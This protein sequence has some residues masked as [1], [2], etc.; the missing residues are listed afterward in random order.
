MAIPRVR[1]NQ[2]DLTPLKE[3][4]VTDRALELIKTATSKGVKVSNRA[5]LIR[6]GISV[7]DADL[8][9]LEGT[10]DTGP[11]PKPVKHTL[12]FEPKTLEGYTMGAVIVDSA[13]QIRAEVL[14]PI[15]GGQAILEFDDAATG[16]SIELFVK[17]PSGEFAG[18][19]S[20]TEAGQRLIRKKADLPGPVITVQPVKP[21]SAAKAAG[22]SA[23]ARLKGRLL[24]GDPKVKVEKVQLLIEVALKPNPTETDFLPI[25]FATTETEGYF[26]T[27]QLV[28]PGPSDFAKLTAAR[29]R[30]GIPGQPPIPIRLASG[31]GGVGSLPERLILFLPAEGAN[32]REASDS[33]AAECACN[34]C[35][36]LDFH[37]RKVLDEFSYFTVVR[38]TEPLIEAYQQEDLDEIN[39]SDLLDDVNDPV[40]R[41]AL[42]G[43]RAPR[44]LVANF[45]SKNRTITRDNAPALVESVKAGQ[46]MRQ[47]LGPARPRRGRLDLNGTAEIDWDE[48]PTVYQ[49]VSV[50]HGH[51]LQFK[52]EWFHDG[53]SIG[54]LLYSLPLAPGQKKQIVVFDWDR[55]E[56]A[57]NVQQLDYQE[58]LYNSLSRDRDVN[59]VASATLQESLEGSSSSRTSSFGFGLGLGAIIPAPVPMGGL[60]GIGGG[61]GSGS[62]SARQTGS[63]TTTASSQQHV[64]DRTVQAANAIRS[65]RATVIQTV[66][67]GERFQ[68]SAE[69]VANYNHCHAMTIQYFEVLRHF[70]VRTRL[71]DVRECLFVPLKMSAFTPK[72]ILRWRGI[73]E[74]CLRRRDLLPAFDALYRIEE[75]RE[76]ATENYYDSIGLPR[77]RFAEEEIQYIEGELF[78]E[79]QL[80]RPR[81]DDSGEFVSA[82]WARWSP[83]LGDP[84]EFFSRFIKAEAKRDEAFARHAGPRIAQAVMDEMQFV[85]ER[86]APGGATTPLP[87]DA[88]LVSDFRHRARL[89]VSLRMSGPAPGIRREHID[90]VRITLDGARGRNV[91]LQE[92]T[93][94]GSLRVIVHSG[95]MRYRTRNLHEPLFAASNIKNDLTAAGDD[96]RVFCPLSQRALRKPRLE[97]VE[98]ANIL[99]AHCNENL[100]YYHQCLWTRMDPQRRFMLLDGVL[101]PGRAN[102]RSVASVVENRLIGVAGN[103]MIMPVAPGYQLDP[104][105]DKSVDLFQHYYEEPLDPAHLSLPTKGVFAEAVMGKCNSCEK[106]EEERFW[107][108]EESPVPD[109]PTTIQ[110]VG[111]P[112]PGPTPV[113][114]QVKDFP[115]P[116]INVQNAPALPDPQGFGALA[117]LLGNANLFRD[118][119][120]L[121]ENQ[122]NALAALQS[123]LQTAQTFGQGAAQLT[124]QAADLAKFN[125]LSEM[126]SKGQISKDDF[127]KFVDKSQSPE[128]S[129]LKGISDA[130]K[131]SEIDPESAARLKDATLKKA[132]AEA[133]KAGAGTGIS[134]AVEEAVRSFKDSAEGSLDVKDAGGSISV[135]KAGPGGGGGGPKTVVLDVPLDTLEPLASS[136]VVVKFHVFEQDGKQKVNFTGTNSGTEDRTILINVSVAQNDG[137]GNAVLKGGQPILTA[138]TSAKVTLKRGDK[139]IDFG[140]AVLVKEIFA[141]LSKDPL[142]FGA[143][144]ASGDPAATIAAGTLFKFPF[145]LSTSAATVEFECVQPPD[146]TGV[147]GNSTHVATRPGDRFAVDFGMPIGTQVFAMRDGRVVAVEEQFPDLAAG[148]TPTAADETRANFV[149]VLHTDGTF[150]VYLHLT[151]DGADVA[152]SDLVTAG[153]TVIGRSGN[154]GFSKGPHLHVAVTRL[155]VDAGLTTTGFDSLPFDFDD[156]TGKAAVLVKGAKFKRTK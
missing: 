18:L 131:K 77:D 140:E 44:L 135:T 127:N 50:A 115:Q 123:S 47:A 118:I 98:A 147:T 14:V 19:K 25:G 146:G 93:N 23:P 17:A 6:L 144:Q 48:K 29:A 20:G 117:T 91:L 132:E 103:C 101:A 68:V 4:G 16:P 102:G 89:N 122:K 116:V 5:D 156:S 138:V 79:F 90:F 30:V 106:K 36:D 32:G 133:A 42:V 108:W 64:S 120:G 78:L 85:A 15:Q 53:Y 119:T 40:V 113:N 148:T 33:A 129:A 34:D 128:L 143:V 3:K 13:T 26:F 137:K 76:S 45:L 62:S 37:D 95:S 27:S 38:T 155:R 139:D 87:I 12:T 52:Q 39:L 63:R 145:A 9:T 130:E 94:E 134:G 74:R 121:T 136:K 151:K 82:A 104:I 153:T 84:L 10:F 125:K 41:G 72:K 21:V 31:A 114:L 67:Q 66:S 58:S 46:M 61:S 51:L 100:E 22:D 73:L 60:L 141:R 57:A 110:P 8:L 54:D 97:D 99:L 43:L 124:T 71:A 112:T 28:F 35:P 154:S 105:L 149:R 152:V 75:E 1:I 49:A 65:Q 92:L 7:A 142:N 24:A 69:V 150:A 55:K 109:S 59:E 88:T 56:S 11:Q 86:N 2:A 83:F 96:V 111:T 81:D 80:T 70:E 107:R 126:L